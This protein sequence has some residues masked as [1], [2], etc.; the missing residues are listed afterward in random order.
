M[1]PKS[2]ARFSIALESRARAAAMPQFSKAVYTRCAASQPGYYIIRLRLQYA[3]P[4]SPA[5]EVS[6]T[7]S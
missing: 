1:N 2:P 6:V 5:I 7:Q 4:I 3:E